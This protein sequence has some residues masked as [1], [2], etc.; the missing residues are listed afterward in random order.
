MGK[1]IK[2]GGEQIRINR[3]GEGVMRF[4]LEGIQK[5]F[6]LKSNRLY[7]R[8]YQPAEQINHIQTQLNYNGLVEEVDIREYS[9]RVECAC[10]NVRWVKNADLFQV[11]KCKPCV[12]RERL[13]RRRMRRKGK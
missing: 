6:V 3:D 1:T 8:P 11:R 2:R 7:E 13:E 4:D 10:G 12:Y 9:N 5:A